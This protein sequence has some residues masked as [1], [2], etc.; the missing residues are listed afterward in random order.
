MAQLSPL[1]YMQDP[2]S[3]DE[4]AQMVQVTTDAK[5]GASFALGDLYNFGIENYEQTFAQAFDDTKIQ[6]VTIQ[7]YA[8]VCRKFPRQRRRWNLSFSHYDTVKALDEAVQ[9]KLLSEAELNQWNREDLRKAKQEYDGTP[10][11]ESIKGTVRVRD[12]LEFLIQD[13]GLSEDDIIDFTAKLYEEENEGSAA[14]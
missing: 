8:N 13:K 1:G 12:I 7:N 3:Y 4:F 6:L 5:N 14:A 10:K 2:T 11:T 9:D